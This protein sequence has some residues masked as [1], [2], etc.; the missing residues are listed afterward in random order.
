MLK[1]LETDT[2][3]HD[4]SCGGPARRRELDRGRAPVLSEAFL[5]GRRANSRLKPVPGAT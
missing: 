4:V 2:D 1:R 3:M 5:K